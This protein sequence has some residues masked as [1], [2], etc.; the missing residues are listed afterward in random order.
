MIV[1]AYVRVS[2]MAQERDDTI[3]SQIAGIR[4]YAGRQ[5]LELREENIF[6]DEGFSGSTLIRP[7]LDQL[8]DRVAEGVFEAVLVF[9]PDRLARTYVHQ[10]L[11][12]EEFTAQG[13]SLQF[14]RRP[15]GQT[16]DEQ[17]L[18]QIQGVIA[19]YERTKIVE[20]TRRGKQHRMRNGELVTGRRTFGY[21]YIPR[22]AE[23]PAR[24]EI[25][26]DE[27]AT[28]RK[29]FDWYAQEGLSS[30]RIATELNRSGICTIAGNKWRGSSV[31]QILNNPLYTGTGYANRVES[32][33]PK[34]DRPL[35]PVYRKY[36][37]TGKRQRPQEEWIPLTSPAVISQEVYDLAQKRFA[38]NK[39]L[40]LRN[41]RNEYLLR[42]F[43]VCEHCGRHMQVYTQ[44]GRYH[45]PYHRRSHA[46]QEGLP[47]CVNPTRYPI[48]E[49]DDAVWR[50]VVGLLR[51]PSILK[52]QYRALKG[53]IVPA[54][55]G[56]TDAL[57]AKRQ[58]LQEQMNRVNRLYIEEAIDKAEHTSRYGQ[59]KD[60]L[61]HLQKQLDQSQEDKLEQTSIDEMLQTFAEFART[62]SSQ[63]DAADFATRR[64][65]TEKIVKQVVIGT[66]AVTIEYA[67]PMKKCNLRTVSGEQ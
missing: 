11:L 66:D 22:S 65:I 16:P 42:G 21:R 38:Q 55:T 14:V 59:L 3:Q 1:G 18:L 50:E 20:R 29:I 57:S 47:Q 6:K 48:Q 41:T 53:K 12:L 25:L 32:V 34:T 15:I 24:Y 9:D 39:E 13:C 43:V 28:V 64:T 31:R 51:K 36:A 45:C 8:R 27:A 23:T 49:I 4:E 17:L 67:V 61:S 19:E 33:L 54:V 63:L 60:Q 2:S 35:N 44:N 62:I 37:K 30:R 5:G 40:S 52:S 7:A 46:E 56:G 10:V 58:K 26:P